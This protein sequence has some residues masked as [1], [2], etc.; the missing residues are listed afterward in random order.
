MR[1][2]ED[3]KDKPQGEGGYKERTQTT[4]R[5]EVHDAF[6]AISV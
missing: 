6:E 5:R 2:N 4:A 3:A 1:R